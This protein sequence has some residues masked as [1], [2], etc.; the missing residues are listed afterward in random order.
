MGPAVAAMPRHAAD[1]LRPC[2]AALGEPLAAEAAP[3]GD[4]GLLVHPS[5]EFA[6]QALVSSTQQVTIARTLPSR[7]DLSRLV[8]GMGGGAC[9]WT[10][11]LWRRAD[12][13]DPSQPANAGKRTGN[14]WLGGDW[15]DLVAVASYLW[16]S[17]YR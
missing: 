13:P 8:R 6:A 1:P 10:R 11:A 17:I 5:A 4:D 9:S 7:L 16:V 14:E 3:G 12:G 15:G 2:G